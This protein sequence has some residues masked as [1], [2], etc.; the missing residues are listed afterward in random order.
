MKFR[1]LAPLAAL[2]FVVPA[3]S[4]SAQNYGHDDAASSNI[5]E[6]AAEAGVFQTLLAALE[7]AGL[8]DVLKSDGP[9]TVFAPTDEAF[10]ALPEGTVEALLQDLDALR[11]ILTYHVAEGKVMAAQVVD[12]DTVPTLQGGTL[13]VS[14]YGG[15]V[16]IGDAAVTTADVEASN[17]VIHIIDTVLIPGN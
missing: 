14:A 4:L 9:F 17:G 10:A 13:P 6:V 2:L 7:A 5:V 16:R 8:D 11:A 1:L 12:M 15:T 3:S